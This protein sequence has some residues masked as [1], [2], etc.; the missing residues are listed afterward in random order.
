MI[1]LPT[2]S[3]KT[4]FYPKKSGGIA[5]FAFLTAVAGLLL[6]CGNA[7]RGIELKTPATSKVSSGI[8]PGVGIN[9]A[10][11]AAGETCTNLIVF[12]GQDTSRVSSLQG[13]SACLQ[14][15]G[16]DLLKIKVGASFGL[17][18]R[19]CVIALAGSQVASVACAAYTQQETVTRLSS[20]SFTHVGFVAETDLNSYLSYLYGYIDAYPTVLFGQIR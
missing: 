13:T 20:T 10:T 18:Q 16:A 2:F 12:P 3:S 1:F 5:L 14:S 8:S 7:D 9:T 17:G 19:Y 11:N 4:G 6:S 15:N